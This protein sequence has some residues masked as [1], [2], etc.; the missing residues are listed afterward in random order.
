M[1]ISCEATGLTFSY[2]TTC[3]KEDENL[4]IIKEAIS[5]LHLRYGLE[6]KIIRSDGEMNRNKTL[7][8]CRKCGI[9]FEKC[10]PNTH[11]QNGIAEMKGRHIMEKARAMRL[12]ARLP[13]ALWTEIISMVIY[14]YNRTPRYGLGWKS[15]YEAFYE[16]VMSAEGVTGPQRPI[17]YH[18]KV[19]GC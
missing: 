7:K 4:P 15:P 1:F 12:S 5:W 9:E 6:V 13:H 8:W 19:Y 3:A 17:L 2:F 18:L 10:A 14:L 16:Y 11:E